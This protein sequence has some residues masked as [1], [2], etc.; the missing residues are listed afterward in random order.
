M[1]KITLTIL[2]MISLVTYAQT[3]RTIL[4]E[5]FTQASC[6]QCAAA[7]PN[8]NKFVANNASKLVSIKYQTAFPG[9]DP[10]NNQNKGEVAT[11]V[12][13]YSVIS[14]PIVSNDGK[15]L[16]TPGSVTQADI[17]TEYTVTS[18]F[19]M[20]I[21][22]QV[23]TTIDSILITCTITAAQDFTTKG[24]FYLRMALVE[25]TIKFAKAPG[26]NGEKEFFSV[27]RKMIPSVSG[28]SLLLN[29][30]K[31]HVEKIVYK[32]AIPSYIYDKNQLSVVGFLQTDNNKA[33]LQAAE[34]VS[35]TTGIISCP[36]APQSTLA[37]VY[38]NP[39][40]NA[41]FISLQ[42]SQPDR[43]MIQLVNSLGQ[44]ILTSDLGQL[45]GGN[46]QAELNTSQIP[47]GV[48]FLN[49]SVGSKLISK[50]ISITR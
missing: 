45:Q 27:M 1:K 5:E 17:N 33:V 23:D 48:Y 31:D 24:P 32:Q 38:P 20:E 12:N 50:K 3:Q 30:T 39:A 15:A 18:P 19:K 34:S 29:W 14:T 42:L 25:K 41:A 8:F 4:L 7:N 10:M 6:S 44:T 35:I 36:A 37:I 2:G 43:V 9:D 49:I 11:R 28:T 13:Y 22:Q 40:A 21:T 26:T 46:Q 16:E 47:Q